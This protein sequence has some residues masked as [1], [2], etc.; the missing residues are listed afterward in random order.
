MRV[1]KSMLF[2]VIIGVSPLSFAQIAV[3]TAKPLS[4]SDIQMLR[5]DV[6]ADKN[7]IITHTM[8]FTDSE[9]KTF[10][11]VYHEY[12]NGQKAIGDQRLALIKDY[13]K[14]YDSMDDA[15]AQGMVQTLFKIED[16]T[17]ALRKEY[18]P[19]FVKA[20]GAKRAARFYQVDNRLTLMVNLQLASIIP[21][22]P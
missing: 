11:P 18:F 2:A 14:N 3:V 8:Q 16:Q 10:W 9:S 6:Q 7:D 21:L 19:R 17:E 4:D 12:A 1:L 15:K 5:Q 20:L 22:V 13:A